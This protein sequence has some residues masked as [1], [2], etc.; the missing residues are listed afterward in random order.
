MRKDKVQ[1]HLRKIH[2]KPRSENNKGICCPESKRM[3]EGL[4]FGT[5]KHGA[6]SPLESTA[7]RGRLDVAKYQYQS[8]ELVPQPPG[9]HTSTVSTSNSLP[10]MASTEY[11][12]LPI[13]DSLFYPMNDPRDL[14]WCNMAS[15]WDP[16]GWGEAITNTDLCYNELAVKANIKRPKRCMDKHWNWWKGCQ[17]SRSKGSWLVPRRSR[18]LTISPKI[19]FSSRCT[20]RITCWSYFWISSQR[21]LDIFYVL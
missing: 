3:Q 2:E 20:T 9:F 12:S 1:T 11:F 5:N 6:A 14:G 10:S 17:G 7:K 15:H 18:V 8:S 21:I 13:N 4:Q 16:A 19:F